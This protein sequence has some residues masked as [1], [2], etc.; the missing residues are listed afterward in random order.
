MTA[1]TRHV[2]P[3]EGRKVRFPITGQVLAPEGAAVE[4]GS[5]WQRLLQGGDVEIFTPPAEAPGA[6]APKTASDSKEG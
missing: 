4:W 3:C 5:Y 6:K 2:R 1:D